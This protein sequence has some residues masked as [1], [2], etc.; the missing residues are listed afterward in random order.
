M[1]R[2]ELLGVRI[3]HMSNEAKD[4]NE[5]TAV[6]RE[7]IELLEAHPFDYAVAGGLATDHWTSGAKHISDIDLMIR[8]LDAPLILKHLGAEGYRT[9]EM[10][11]SWLHKAFRGGVTIDLMFELKN[12]TRFDDR[13]MEHRTKGEMFGTTVHVMSPEDQIASLAG[14]VDRQTIGQHWFSMIDIL[15]NN[16]LDWDYLL[17]RA[18]SVPFQL[19]SVLYFALS[20]NVPVRKG[21]IETLARVAA[22][23]DT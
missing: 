2:G 19:L 17:V 14:T 8:D 20:R 15:S 4:Q 16:D 10:E 9:I 13:F 18:E 23:T 3:W 6:F 7:V 11:H 5:A 22:A 12:G 21:V 1:Y